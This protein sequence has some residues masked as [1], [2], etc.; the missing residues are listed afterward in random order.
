MK[1]I[2]EKCQK[3]TYN[4]KGKI[5][6]LIECKAETC[7]NSQVRKWSKNLNEVKKYLALSYKTNWRIY[8]I[9]SNHIK[10]IK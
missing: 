3:S 6:M 4:I 5:N 2:R 1:I 10:Q 9:I 7:L 8:K